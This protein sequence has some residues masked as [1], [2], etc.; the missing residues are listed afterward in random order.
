MI[1]G[2]DPSMSTMTIIV[3]ALNLSVKKQ[4]LTDGIFLKSI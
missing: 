2:I 4:R 1:V 3:N